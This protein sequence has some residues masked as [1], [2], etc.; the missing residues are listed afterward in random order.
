MIKQQTIKIE[1]SQEEADLWK[2]KARSI[3]LSRSDYLLCL[4]QRRDRRF[5][6]PGTF[7]LYKE[8]CPGKR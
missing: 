4:L 1:A 3:G 6:L 8:P 2:E 7:S 5:P